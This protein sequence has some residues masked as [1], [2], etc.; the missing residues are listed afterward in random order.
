MRTTLATPSRSHRAPLRRVLAAVATTAAL[1][2]VSFVIAPGAPASAVGTAT[3]GVTATDAATLA[4]AFAGGGDVTLGESFG[5]TADDAP[6]VVPSGTSVTLNLNGYELT[7]AGAINQAGIGVPDTATL[8]ITDSSAGNGIL[9]ATGGE[10]GAGIGGGQ[11][12]AGGS[13]AI[14]SGTVTATGGY[15]G[16][17]IGGGYYG[18]ADRNITITSGIVTAI[19]GENGAGIGGGYGGAGGKITIASGTVT[20]T[21]GQYGAGVGGGFFGSGGNITIAGGTVVSTAGQFAAGIGG[22]YFADGKDIM[23]TDSTVTATAGGQSAGIGG[24][25][26]GAGGNITITDST[27]TAT[28]AEW[29]AGIG[30]GQT[31]SGGDLTITDSTVTATGGLFAA[32]IGGGYDGAGGTTEITSSTVTAT[33][34]ENAA[35]IGGGQNAAGGNTVITDST[36]TATGGRFGAGIGGGYNGAGGGTEITGGNVTGGNVTATGGYGGAGIGGGYGGAGAAVVIGTD[37]R[38]TVSASPVTPSIVIGAGQGGSGFG[39]LANAGTLTITAGSTLV[40]PVGTTVANSGVIRN[41]GTIAVNGTITNSGSIITAADRVTSPVNVTGRNYLVT[42]DGSP[43]DTPSTLAPL[44]VFSTTFADAELDLPPTPVAAGHSFGGWFTDAARSIPMT[45][46]TALSPDFTVYAKWTTDPR[47]VTFSSEGGTDIGPVTT[48]YGT[49]ITPPAKPTRT[50]YTFA[51]WYTAATSGSEWDF[52]AA[53][54]TD[55][56]AYA[57]WTAEKRT[58]T[59][60]S[61]GGSAVKAIITNYDTVIKAPKSTRTGYAFKG[62]YTKSTGGSAWNFNAKVTKNA[63]AYA[64]WTVQ[65]RTVTFNAQGGSKVAT[66]STNY[67]T[68]IKAPKSPTRTGYSFAGWYTKSTGGSA[69]KFTSKVTA[70]TTAYAHWTVLKKNVT[71]NTQG[72]SKVATVSTNYNTAIKAPKSPTRSGYTFTGWYTKATGGSVWKFTA[73]VTAN[74][75]VYAHWTVKR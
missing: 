70:N 35:G 36:V 59:F 4:A 72:G 16:A 9:A 28:G 57:H 1:L 21:G 46:T 47:T 58:V 10:N 26:R 38:V 15:G 45:T 5:V 61:Q 23:I 53:V 67:N 41:Q 17:G 75:T 14:T 71:F 12:G 31:R 34:G 24:G 64:H 73:K 11:Y 32:G 19:G 27:V 37:A 62:W 6:I 51:G 40:I 60:S 43:G 7:V 25:Y 69:W 39:S 49:T 55:A 74:T 50:G 18:A 22:G 65:K 68:A 20:A 66:A 29:G 44:Y 8:T 3:D 48:D 63:T 54:T 13:I 2:A 30:G 52:T 42:F 56:T 33:G